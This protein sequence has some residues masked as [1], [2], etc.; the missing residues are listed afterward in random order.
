M[1]SFNHV[2]GAVFFKKMNY[3]VT[4]SVGILQP[5]LILSNPLS[6]DIVVDIESI[7]GFAIGKWLTFVT[8]ELSHS[9]VDDGDYQSGPY[10]VMIPAGSTNALFDVRI[11]DDNIFEI[12][13]QF[14]YL[15]ITQTSQPILVIPVPEQVRVTIL[16]DDRKLFVI[17]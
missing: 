8:H 16:D 12:L 10:T 2:V 13:P 9:G 4:E 6:M 15:V 3:T 7:D 11:T 5:E 17:S 14:F 1:I